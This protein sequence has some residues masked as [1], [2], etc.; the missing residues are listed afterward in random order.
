MKG[1]SEIRNFEA[2]PPHPAV[3]T[4]YKLLIGAPTRGARAARRPSSSVLHA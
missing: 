3:R 1:D 4:S 2:V